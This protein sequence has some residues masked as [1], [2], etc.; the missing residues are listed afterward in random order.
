MGRWWSKIEG[1]STFTLCVRLTRHVCV[2]VC[3]CVCVWF[4]LL[5]CNI[6]KELFLYFCIKLCHKILMFHVN[7]QDCLHLC[8]PYFITLLH[9]AFPFILHILHSCDGYGNPLLDS[10][11]SDRVIHTWDTYFIWQCMVCCSM[12][13]ATL[14]GH[15]ALTTTMLIVGSGIVLI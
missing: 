13:T 12:W 4:Y 3:V 5:R 15:Q 14:A 11:G 1:W 8:L 7:L 9:T 10:L 6:G 2:C